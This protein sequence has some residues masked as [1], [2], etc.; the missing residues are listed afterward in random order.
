MNR[1][2][3]FK[4]EILKYKPYFLAENPKVSVSGYIRL[5]SAS[6]TS[7]GLETHGIYNIVEYYIVP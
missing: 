3:N 2:V 4:N 7:I 6:Q 5:F 1:S